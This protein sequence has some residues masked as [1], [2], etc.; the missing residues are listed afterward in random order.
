VGGVVD[1]GD[2]DGRGDTALNWAAY[3]CDFGRYMPPVRPG[4]S[5]YLTD[6][7]VTYK[8]TAL[9]AVRPFWASRFNETTVHWALEARGETLWLDPAIIV[10]QQRS[11][12]LEDAIRE[13]YA[14]GRLFATTRV[15]ATTLPGRAVYAAGSLLLPGLLVGRLAVG[16]A[17]K[18]RGGRE[19][20]R[21][22]PALGV[23]STVWAWGELVGYVTGRPA[24]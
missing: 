17:R 10:R 20:L 9:E 5:S 4:R 11:V 19:L 2:R 13:R 18:G 3:L 7:N 24:Q 14:F 1:K 21:A 16:V 23:L 8:R 6:C 12:R 22:L 15:A